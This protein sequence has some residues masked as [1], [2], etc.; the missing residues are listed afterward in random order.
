MLKTYYSSNWKIH[1]VIMAQSLTQNESY[2]AHVTSNREP[3]THLWPILNHWDE[4]GR[5]MSWK[6]RPII[7]HAKSD[8]V[9]L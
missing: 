2:N 4:S 9:D 6:L 5:G 8:E 7:V 3:I 1:A